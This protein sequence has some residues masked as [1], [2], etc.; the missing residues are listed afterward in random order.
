[1]LEKLLRTKAV[2]RSV[3]PSCGPLVF[4]S[5]APTKVGPAAEL[6]FQAAMTRTAP[7]IA[8]TTL[9]IAMI[10]SQ[11]AAAQMFGGFG[12]DVGVPYPAYYSRVYGYPYGY[13]SYPYYGAYTTPYGY[14]SYPYYYGAYP[15]S[16]WNSGWGGFFGGLGSVA[17]APVEVAGT[18]VTAP[19]A[20]AANMQAPIT[21]G[22]SVAA[23]QP[24]YGTR[25][26]RIQRHAYNARRMHY[27]RNAENR[28]PTHRGRSAYSPGMTR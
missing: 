13:A 25:T 23:A 1:V 4:C 22:R 21:T 5:L 2:E 12:I 19:F 16:A 26:S 27:S 14:A 18:A 28:Y 17:A 3:E 8:A 7:Y 9:G 11:P 24:Y 10:V 15:Y 20:T 6:L